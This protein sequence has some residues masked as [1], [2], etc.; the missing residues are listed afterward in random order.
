MLFRF[1]KAGL[2]ALLMSPELVTSSPTYRLAVSPLQLVTSE[3]DFAPFARQV[4]KDVASALQ[5][6]PPPEGARLKLL[7]GIKV[8]LA[9]HFGDNAAALD[10]AERIR[11][12]QTDRAERA[13][14]GLTTRALVASNHEPH[15]FGREFTRLLEQLPHDPAIR[16]ALVRARQ[17]IEAMTEQSLLDDVRNVAPL[18]ARGEPC[19]LEVADQLVRVRHRLTGILPLREAMLR[20]YDVALSRQK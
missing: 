7:L 18:L 6:A 15:A 11:E 4:F 5:S 12:L 14:A 3:T 13:L 17:R 20:S 9:L 10:A 8:H 1:L 2:V 19:T 16:G